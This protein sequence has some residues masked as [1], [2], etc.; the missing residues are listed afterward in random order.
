MHLVGVLCCNSTLLRILSYVYVC[1]EILRPRWERGAR[2]RFTY[3]PILQGGG[4]GDEGE[5]LEVG[6]ATSQRVRIL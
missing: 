2:D 4:G 3:I 6:R 5:H 1:T